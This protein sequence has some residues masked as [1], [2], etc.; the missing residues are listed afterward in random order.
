MLAAPLMDS[1]NERLRIK[2]SHDHVRRRRLYRRRVEF[3]WR[4]FNFGEMLIEQTMPRS[5][6]AK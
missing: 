4:P 6:R 5:L 3:C 2:Q 1:V